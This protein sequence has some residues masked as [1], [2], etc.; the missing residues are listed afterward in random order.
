[1][2]QRGRP[3]GQKNKPKYVGVKLSDLNSIFL[4]DTVIQV[5][6]EYLRF[7]N[8]TVDSARFEGYND[9]NESISNPAPVNF[10]EIE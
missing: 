2:G 1:M 10:T 5:N 7:L 4:Q 6:P 9:W 3:P 8:I